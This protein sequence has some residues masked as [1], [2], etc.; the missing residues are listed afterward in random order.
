MD[1]VLPCSTSDRA[2]MPVEHGNQ[3]PVR[4]CRHTLPNVNDFVVFQTLN[5][6]VTSDGHTVIDN[7]SGVSTQVALYWKSDTT[8]LDQF[9][10]FLVD[11]LSM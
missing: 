8:G 4:C 7:N 9:R 1:W 10:K 6:T 5:L 11:V 2:T 3:S